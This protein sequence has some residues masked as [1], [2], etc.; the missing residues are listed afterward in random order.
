MI[1]SNTLKNFLD[2]NY[3]KIVSM[4]SKICKC[5]EYEE[6]AHHVITEFIN[7]PKAERLILNENNEA[8]AFISLIVRNQYFSK[9]SPY[10]KLYRQSG[11]VYN[12]R[13]IPEIEEESYDHS[14]DF[15]L[16]MIEGI[17]EEM[18]LDRG[19]QWYQA[20]LFRLWIESG[21][22]SEIHRQTGIPRQSIANAISECKEYIKETIKNRVTK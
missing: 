12:D 1:I 8:M 20:S 10:H 3:E 5:S 2:G 17:L 21:N 11:R 15:Q 16:E 6:L 14:K 9:N 7:N 4:T 13:A 19:E 18:E 22:V